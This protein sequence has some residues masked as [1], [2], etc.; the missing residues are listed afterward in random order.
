MTAIHPPGPRVP[1]RPRVLLVDNYDSFTYNLAHLLCE[2]GAEV[3]VRR[4]DEVSEEEAEALAPTH[5]VVSPG[6]GRPDDAGVSKAL[7]ARFAG[8]VPILG[9]CLGHQCIVEVFGG[10]VGPASRLMHGKVG[11]VLQLAPDPV[12]ALL[13]AEF[14]AGRYHSLAA[15]EPLPEELEVTARDRD[16]E[17]MALR[18]R[19]LAALHGVQFHPESILTPDG[20]LIARA[21]LA[22]GEG[23]ARPGSSRLGRPRQ[24]GAGSSSIRLPEIL[25]RL[26]AGEDLSEAEAERALE[27]VMRGEASGAEIAAL[28]VAL[29]VKG[30]AVPEIVGAARAMRTHAVAVRPERTDL[31]DTAGT[32]GDGLHTINISTLAG[33][34]AAGAG[35]GVAKHGNRAVS[36]ATGSADVLAALGVQIALPHERV[37]ACIDEVGF[38]FLFAPSHHPAMRHAIPVR[39][40]L[41]VRT[42]FNL[43][44]PLTNPVGAR[45]QLVGVYAEQ[46]VEPMAETLRTLG[47]ERSLVVHGDDGLDELSPTGRSLC[48]VATPEGVQIERI[49]PRELGIAP[50]SVEDLRGGD[51]RTNAELALAVLDGERGPRRDAAVLNAAAALVAAGRAATIADGMASAAEA[52]D[53]GAA[54]ATLEAL[55]TFTNASPEAVPA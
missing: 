27:L 30:E 53:S 37:A 38:G 44:G 3:E 45:R 34:I 43:L 16:G 11:N 36:S 23:V 48:A 20:E 7:I 21:F 2:A 14:E 19:T 55:R 50:C 49:D 1:D 12:L 51:P 46:L 35:A 31:V 22:M 15:H 18:H 17:V 28:L 4:N 24:P 32:G 42:I 41:G 29:R 13:P 25:P 40:A 54:R 26:L 10:I 52:V 9:V 8:R 5:L 39:R 6:P 47:S 33:L